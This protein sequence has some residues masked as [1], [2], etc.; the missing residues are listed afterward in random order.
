MSVPVS[1]PRLAGAL[2]AT[3]LALH[4]PAFAA[5]PTPPQAAT[6]L[7]AAA[8][9]LSAKKPITHDVYAEWRSIQGTQLS[10]DGQ[11]LAYALV[12]QEADGELV[13]RRLADGQEWRVPRGTAPQ[14]S[15]D[16]RHVAFAVQP[17]RAELDK[18]KKDKKKGDDAP[19][20]GAGWMELATGKVEQLAR[21]KRFAW[22]EEGSGHLALLLEPPAARGGA[23][24]AKAEAAKADTF[25]PALEDQEAPPPGTQAGLFPGSSAEGAAAGKKQPGSEL[26]LVDLASGLRQS[27]KDVAEFQ[28]A[29]DGQ[30]L[31]YVVALKDAKDSAKDGSKDSG[32]EAKEGAASPPARGDETN[33]REGVYLLAPAGGAVQALLTGAG[34][35]RQLRFD[36]E[37]RQLAFVSN[38]DHL[39]EKAAERATEKAAGKPTE[40]AQD[41]ADAKPEPTPFKLYL[42]RQGEAQARSLVAAGQPGLPEGWGPSEHAALNFSKDGRRLFLGTA[43]LPAAEPKDAP[44]PLKVDLWHWKDPELQSVQ[45]VKAEREKQRSYRAVVHLDG[46]AAR[47]VQLA[48]PEIP[49]VVVNENAG[50]A[51]GLSELPYRQLMS[52]EGVYMDAYALDL[53]TGQSRLLAKKLRHTPRLSPGGRY[54]LGFDA[55]AL[56]WLA[57]ST[58]GAR[59]LDL[60]GSIKARFDNIERDVPDLPAP[61]GVA[62]W[63]ADDDAVVLYDQF[64]L[65]A[66]RPQDGS[67]RNL[68]QG[69]GRQHQLQLRH[70]PL[71]P[72]DADAK[73]LPADTLMLSAVHEVQRDSGYF[74]VAA[75][76][77]QPQKLI[78]APKMIGGLIKAKNADR[79]VF[80]QQSF[81]EFP[82]L[83]TDTL[84]LSAPQQLS[85]AN[86]QQAALRWGTQEL[87]SYKTAAGKTL[88]ALL[89]KPEDFDPAKKYPLMVYIYEKMTDNRYRFVAPAPGQNINVT[90]YV[91]NGYLVLR[92][93]LEY[94]TGHPG[95]SA[96][97]AVVPAVR[98]LIAK[99]FVDPK[100]VGIQGHSWGAYQINYLITQTDLFAAAEAGA[101]MANMTS[102][103]GGIRWGTGLSRAFQYEHGQSRM[104]T[105]PWQRPDLYLQNS[106]LFHIDKVRTPYLTVHN[107]EDDAVPWYQGI[108]MF[109][110]L[111]RL[112][113]EA[114][115]FNYNGEKHGLRDRDNIKHF[116]VHMAEF[117]DHYLL[118][119]PRPAWMDQPV[120]Y[121][122]RG[123]RD[124]M[125]LFRPQPQK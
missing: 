2:I 37:G 23:A 73:P 17:T 11:W 24:G 66:V 114:Y 41:K 57:W 122:E 15:P 65:W 125:P 5:T 71:D 102:G 12:A 4:A 123:R 105:T 3:H 26:V 35:Y 20:P 54:V 22:A 79:V 97:E 93:D 55:Q 116:T 46:E 60:T 88:R 115:W 91:S 9:V 119:S 38:R 34:H 48:T 51:L 42:W 29:R 110:A 59:R 64:D 70:V 76:G 121:L 101:S 89:A 80:T 10:R 14:F 120:P 90:R 96:L 92:P 74:R 94:T 56:R 52:W 98:Q 8:A 44:E 47:F 118:G 67:A 16:G 84:Q 78:L 13:L 31:A 6:P 49:H 83:W 95:R 19:K 63:T 53:Q 104:G 43:K 36:R 69:Y 77:G 107:D 72:E 108:E 40:K 68:T 99:G 45:K 58:D 75:G 61:Y 50:S 1:L 25:E 82:D 18:A 27:I 30:R 124:V 86:P 33:A 28:W 87:I 109:T 21:V 106:P 100:R 39:A 7:A 117:F 111:R 81:T 32:K 113:K 62:G 85:A 112:G 103:Y